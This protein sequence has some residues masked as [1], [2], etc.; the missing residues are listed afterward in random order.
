MLITMWKSYCCQKPNQVRKVNSHATCCMSKN[1]KNWFS[2]GVSSAL[3][4]LVPCK[5]FKA[6]IFVLNFPAQET[7]K[8]IKAVDLY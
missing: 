1:N 5:V 2:F 3:K 4:A 6:K 7:F 8:E